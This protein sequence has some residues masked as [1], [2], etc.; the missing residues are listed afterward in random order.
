MGQASHGGQA[1]GSSMAPTVALA[2]GLMS[3]KE[4]GAGRSRQPR[5]P[6]TTSHPEP[7]LVEAHAGRTLFPGQPR[8][9]GS[10]L[11]LSLPPPC[12]PCSHPSGSGACSG[13]RA[14]ASAVP[15][16]RCTVPRAVVRLPIP[17]WAPCGLGEAS[18][19]VF[20]P[21]TCDSIASVLRRLCLLDSDISPPATWT[22]PAP[23]GCVTSKCLWSEQ[24]TSPSSW[25]ADTML[26]GFFGLCCPHNTPRSG[27]P[28]PTVATRCGV[29][30]PQQVLSK[31]PGR[32]EGWLMAGTRT[33]PAP[34]TAPPISWSLS[35]L[36][37]KT[38]GLRMGRGP[39]AWVSGHTSS[40]GHTAWTPFP[41]TSR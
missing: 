23:G 31:H 38:G 39:A 26:F 20:M 4:L 12:S 27:G 17:V 5:G 34:G 40:G 24:T 15:S 41:G 32:K 19:P 1:T 30:G 8:M 29:P 3:W 10:P 13:L 37:C 6:S 35:L 25:A 16:T 36:G 21:R 7:A 33:T 11:A 9:R 22:L 2:Q 28:L 18:L 14:P